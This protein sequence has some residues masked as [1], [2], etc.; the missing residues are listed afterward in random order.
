MRGSKAW[1][2]RAF[3]GFHMDYMPKS[4]EHLNFLRGLFS[5]FKCNHEWTNWLLLPLSELP[6]DVVLPQAD[7]IFSPIVFYVIFSSSPFFSL[8]Y[9]PRTKLKLKLKLKIY[10]AI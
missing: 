9:E 4:C 5:N 10:F 2:H 1:V 6:T 8:S 7:P 3:S